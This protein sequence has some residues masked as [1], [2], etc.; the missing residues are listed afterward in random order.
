[1]ANDLLPVPEASVV[2]RALR[3]RPHGPRCGRIGGPE[4][5]GSVTPARRGLGWADA[6]VVGSARIELDP[7]VRGPEPGHRVPT[8]FYSIRCDL[9]YASGPE[10]VLGQIHRDPANCRVGHCDQSCRQI[11]YL[12][13]YRTGSD[14]LSFNPPLR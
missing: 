11:P 9:R 12:S 13:F 1:M 10:S 3:A 8:L 7:T 14:W 6:L 2:K 4:G 5:R